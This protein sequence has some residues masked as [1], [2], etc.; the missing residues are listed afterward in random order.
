MIGSQA[1]DLEMVREDAPAENENVV[2]KRMGLQEWY[3]V[4]V[5]AVTVIMWCCFD[6]L[7]PVFGNM[8]IVALIPVLALYGPGLLT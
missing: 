8:G 1:G 4:A 6:S 2:T 7:K 3:V 5:V